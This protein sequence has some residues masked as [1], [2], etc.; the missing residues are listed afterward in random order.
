[1]A[2]DIGHWRAISERC[3]V[4]VPD[5]R[6]AVR[7]CERAIIPVTAVRQCVVHLYRENYLRETIT[8]TRTKAAAQMQMRRWLT[9]Y[10]VLLAE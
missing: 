6:F 4:Y 9:A 5:E 10:P 7:L 1:V 8:I 2:D 3:Y